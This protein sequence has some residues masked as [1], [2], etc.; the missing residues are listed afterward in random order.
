MVHHRK[1]QQGMPNL[2]NQRG[3]AVRMSWELRSMGKWGLNLHTV[4]P[5]ITGLCR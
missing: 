2:V 1:V 5:G 4:K 3:D